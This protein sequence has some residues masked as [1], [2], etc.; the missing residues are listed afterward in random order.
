MP[1]FFS[2]AC[3]LRAFPLLRYPLKGKKRVSPP[4]KPTVPQSRL[5]SLLPPNRD[6]RLLLISLRTLQRTVPFFSLEC[7]PFPFYC[8]YFT[9]GV[10]FWGIVSRGSHLSVFLSPTSPQPPHCKVFSPHFLVGRARTA[11]F[12]FFYSV[13]SKATKFHHVIHRCHRFPPQRGTKSELIVICRCTN[14]P[15]VSTP[16]TFPF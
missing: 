5:Q 10:V 13:Y 15:S 14:L 2:L 6:E 3:L 1:K 12:V 4:P 16:T 11:C 9:W 7:V 8:V